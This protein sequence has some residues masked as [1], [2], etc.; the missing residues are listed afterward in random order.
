MHTNVKVIIYFPRLGI[1]FMEYFKKSLNITYVL[2]LYNIL[3]LIVFTQSTDKYL[4][5]LNTICHD[6]K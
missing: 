5:H 2:I 1:F 3:I 6:R 4:W